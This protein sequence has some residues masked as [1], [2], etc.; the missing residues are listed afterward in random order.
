MKPKQKP[1]LTLLFIAI[2]LTLSNTAEAA[3]PNINLTTKP[4]HTLGEKITIT[5]N[6]TADGTLITDALVT[7]QVLNPRNETIALRSLTTGSNPPS[8]LF[9]EILEFY[10]CDSAGNPKYSFKR[11]GDMGFKIKIKNNAATSYTI[12]VPI[13]IQYSNELPY[14]VFEIYE[15]TI[16]PYQPLSV[17]TWPVPIPSD[18][19]LGTTKAY[20]N[21]IDK[22]PK[23][24]GRAYALEKETTFQ[25]TASTS[26][27]S[28]SSYTPTQTTEGTFTLS[29]ITNP[30]GGILGNYTIHA[31]S[32]YLPYF[33]TA[34]TTTKVIL[35]GDITGPY[36]VPDGKVDMRDV[37]KVSKAFGKTVPPADPICDLNKD[38]KVDMKDV[39]LV[40]KDFGKYGTLP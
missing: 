39:A 34:K 25:I 6:I 38:G 16:D 36:G 17:G 37:A 21:I 33:L 40:S 30:Y 3:P 14:K 32:L 13:Y 20:A 5:G 24:N 26:S 4:L 28:Y 11:G 10:P 35:I 7:V 9:M 12:K 15:G 8:N 27:T 18:A 1:L 19:P 29:L 23:D 31:T 2:I 22:Y